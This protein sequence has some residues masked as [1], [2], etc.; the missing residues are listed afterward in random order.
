MNVYSEI[1]MNKKHYSVMDEI[2]LLIF[3][4]IKI[5]K[6]SNFKLG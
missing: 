2:V 6:R 1:L 5:S 4:R 3:S